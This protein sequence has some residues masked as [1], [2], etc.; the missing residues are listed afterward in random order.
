[1]VLPAGGVV[2]EDIEAEL[3]R[4]ALDRSN[5]RIEPAAQL[6][7]ITYKTLQYRIKKYELKSTQDEARNGSGV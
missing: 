7:G 3:I 5:G 6:L 2:L 1:M 4:Q